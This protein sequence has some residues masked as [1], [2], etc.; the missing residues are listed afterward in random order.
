LNAYH[1]KD[2]T[3]NQKSDK[4]PLSQ[5]AKYSAMEQL[6]DKQLTVLKEIK[7]S[8]ASMEPPTND[9]PHEFGQ[10]TG[11]GVGDQ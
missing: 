10:P 3:K 11:P 5:P 7:V 6:L 2:Q 4:I 1:N 8:V 9:M